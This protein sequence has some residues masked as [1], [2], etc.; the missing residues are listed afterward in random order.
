MI[1]KRQRVSRFGLLS[2][3]LAVLVLL[4]GCRS[5]PPQQPLQRFQFTHPAMGTLI[6]ITLYTPDQTAAKAAAGAAFQRI[7]ALE[8]IMSDYQADSEVMRLCDQP[9]GTPVPVSMELFDVLQRAHEGPKPSR[10]AGA[11]AGGAAP[12]RS[13]LRNAGARQHGTIRCP[14]ARPEGLKTLRWRVRRDRGS[15]HPAVA[16][17]AEAKSPPHARRNCCRW[18]GG[19]LAE[20]AI[21]RAQAHRDLAR[22]EHASRPRRHRQRLCR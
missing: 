8:D 20:A 11:R 9:F 4:T 22:A 14:P 12:V 2:A 7:D 6:T 19:G 21:R 16:V 15:L 5:A 18:G 1:G 10:G 13:A 17:C 3:L